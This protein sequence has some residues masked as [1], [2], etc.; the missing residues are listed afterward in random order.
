MPPPAPVAGVT[1]IVLGRSD[2]PL[3]QRF[4]DDNPAYFLTVQGAPAGPSEALDEI[5]SLPPASYPFNET[6][7]I[8][9][10]A[11]SGA[12]IALANVVTDFLAPGVWLIGTFYV[13]T[14]RHG[15]GLAHTLYDS[16]ER[17][18][19]AHGARW[20]RLGVVLGNT[21]AER[22]W[23]R[24]GFQNVKIRHGVVIGKRTNAL[25]VMVKSLAGET[26]DCYRELVAH[27]RE[28]GSCSKR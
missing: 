8:G 3:L 5:T 28:E 16:I 17:W 20:L 19:S 15:T 27:D 7:V 22:F 23:T 26:V 10:R 2:A 24:V 14:E 9:Y 18:A 13:A 11:E 12:L 4:F 25:Q 1:S 6:Y 21:R